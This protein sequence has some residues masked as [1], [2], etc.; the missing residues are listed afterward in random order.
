M[1]TLN[2]YISNYRV[3]DQVSQLRIGNSLYKIKDPAVELLASYI[4]TI[5]NTPGSVTIRTQAYD[6]GLTAYNF[7]TRVTQ[8]VNG[9]I[10]AEKARPNTGDIISKTAVGNSGADSTLADI[11]S[12]IIGDGDDTKDSQSIEGAKKY[13]AD[14]VDSLS[15]Q[16]VAEAAKQISYILDEL[17]ESSEGSYLNTL[18]DK[19]RD[20]K[21]SNGDSMNVG[22]YVTS[23]IDALDATVNDADDSSF[24]NVEVVQT[25]GK[26]T[27]I[28]V[29]TN[30]I[31]KASN[32]TLLNSTTQ[33]VDNIVPT[34]ENE[35]ISFGGSYTFI[36]PV[37]L[38]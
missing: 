21:D 37:T 6:S 33:R 20:V 13:A 5:V 26:L 11:L 32:L 1:S 8:D 38:A 12:T 9:Q 35:I 10:T 22:A 16:G 7:L 14:L 3:G 4:D 25:D 27:G 36:N 29:G 15:E 19:L 23:K 17:N 28:T 2:A 18:V 30:D 24:V 34:Y 31:A